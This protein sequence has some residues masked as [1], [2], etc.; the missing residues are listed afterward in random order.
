MW[1]RLL[2]DDQDA[3]VGAGL[4]D[5]RWLDRYGPILVEL[6]LAAHRESGSIVHG[7]VRSDNL[8]ILPGGEARLVDCSSTGRGHRLHDLVE[9]LPTW[10]L[11]GGPAPASVL[12]VPAPLL[13][14][15]SG[16]AIARALD[17]DVQ[18]ARLRDALHDLARITLCWIAHVLEADPPAGR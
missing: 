16:P 17:Q 3:L 12:D 8:C 4:C 15:M 1:Q 13:V 18:P 7:D 10:R 5:R 2:D 11:E 9:F 6:D 14:R